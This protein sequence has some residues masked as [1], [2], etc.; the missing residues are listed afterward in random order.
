[1]GERNGVRDDQDERMNALLGGVQ[2]ELATRPDV[3][4]VDEEPSGPSLNSIPEPS[5]RVKFSADK[6]QMVE[7][8]LLDSRSLHMEQDEV[9]GCPDVSST[10]SGQEDGR[11]GQE[12]LLDST[13]TEPSVGDMHS[14]T[15]GQLIEDALLDSDSPDVKDGGWSN[16]DAM[17]GCH[18]SRTGQDEMGE[19]RGGLQ[20]C[21]KPEP[22]TSSDVKLIL[23]ATGRDTGVNNA[24]MCT[25]GK[26]C[27]TG[28]EGERDAVL[29]DQ[30]SLM[31]QDDSKEQSSPDAKQ[32]HGEGGSGVRIQEGELRDPDSQRVEGGSSTPGT[33]PTGAR[34]CT[35]SKGG[36]VCDIHGPGA[37][38]HWR[39][40]K[41]EDQVP[42]PDG[43]VKTRFYFWVCKLGPKGRGRLRQM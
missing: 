32:C 13:T 35:Y 17:L 19:M 27:W 5:M 34:V 8:D 33:I 24:N 29:K 22:S 21:P 31:S 3:G 10:R 28:C 20:E 30:S 11:E 4:G 40:I 39:P 15:K 6:G 26:T 9:E 37:K 42:G 36:G 43:K 18:S 12:A 23:H 41:K 14:A 25:A 1:M 16:K 2:D 38:Y 7:D